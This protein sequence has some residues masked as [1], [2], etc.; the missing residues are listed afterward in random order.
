MTDSPKDPSDDLTAPLGL[1]KKSKRTAGLW[2]GLPKIVAGV[3]A[4]FVLVFLG[5]AMF[6]SAPFG[7]EPMA[8]VPANV[9]ADDSSTP[10]QGAANDRDGGPRVLAADNSANGPPARPNRYDG[11][12]S[13]SAAPGTI[14]VAAPGTVTIIDG[15]NGKRQEVVLAP[16]PSDPASAPAQRGDPRLTE[17]SRFGPLPRIASDGER[18]SQAFAQPAATRPDSA[19]VPRV[20]LI[21]GGLGISASGTSAAL[22]RLPGAVTFA[23]APYGADL[24]RLGARA[25]EADHELLLQIPMEPIDYPNNDPGPQ[26][27]LTSLD[28]DHNL[29]RLHWLMGR[30]QGYVGIANY[31]GARFTASEPALTPVLRE[32]AKRGLIY[33][34]DGSSPRSIAGQLAGANNLPYTKADVIIDSVGSG[35]EI[36]RALMRLETIARERGVA[37]GIAKAQTT[38]IEHI[39]TW[40][41]NAERHGIVLVPITA[42]AAKAKSS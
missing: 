19:N 27:L 16:E 34:E 9:Q 17:P 18:P 28:A 40:A 8:I 23:F 30:M 39:A 3:L 22:A 24:D 4:A 21:V 26:T 25:R 14:P 15:T 1:D 13:Q 20:A 42:V 41:K 29:Q 32:A 38:S 33:V 5:W 7:G 2:T 12:P 37:V 36:D 35:F 31:M 11:P 6:A 10:K